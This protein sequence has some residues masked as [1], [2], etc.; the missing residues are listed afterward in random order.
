MLLM[1]A[2]DVDEECLLCDDDY[3]DDDD[4]VPRSCSIHLVLV[5]V[6]AV[7]PT[8]S[9]PIHTFVVRRLLLF[10]L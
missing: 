4:G 9:C 10:A 2:V 1:I 3:D 6:V 7:N 5:L 8:T